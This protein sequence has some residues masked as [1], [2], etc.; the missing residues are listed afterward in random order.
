M[1]RGGRALEPTVYTLEDFTDT[2]APYE[3]LYQF[4]GDKFTLTRELE[5][6]SKIAIK[7]GFRG[8][9][10]AYGE[11]V[12]QQKQI[13]ESLYLDAVTQFE[14]QPLELSCGKWRA[15]EDGVYIETQFGE[16]EAC[17]HPIL[18]VLRLVNIDT[19]V[20]KLR[21]AYRKGGRWRSALAEKKTL[22]SNSA[23][24]DLANVGVAVTSENSRLLVRY[25]HDL[26]SLNYHRIPEKQSV[27]R[28]GWV[29]DGFSPYVDGLVF[30]GEDSFRPIFQAVKEGGSYGRW[31]ETARGAR[32]DGSIPARMALAGSFASVLV[33]KADALS[34]FVHLWG[35]TGAGKTVGL[36]LAASVW[37]DPS[38]GE[39]LRTFNGSLVGNE[40][41]AGFLGSMPLILDEFQ[42]LKNKRDFEQ[43][44]YLLSEGVG[45]TRGAKTGGIQRTPTWKNCILTSGE[46][47]ITN[48]LSG[49]GAYNR[50]LE[51]ECEGPLFPNPMEIVP[52]I[53]QNYGFAGREFV[54]RLLEEGGTGE[55]VALYREFYRTLCGEDTTEKQAMAGAL[56]LAADTLATR[57]IF[58]DGRALTPGE[59]A[60]Y[61][62]SKAEVDANQRAYHYLCEM[63]ATNANR[64]HQNENGEVW[65]KVQ[66]GKAYIIRSVFQH[67]CEEGGYS[68]RAVLS[69]MAKNGYIDTY[70]EPKTGKQLYTV[71]TSTAGMNTRHV[72]LHL[73][74]EPPEEDYIEDL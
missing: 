33:A 71:M 68:S 67:L 43:T 64:F 48:F 30:D 49:G 37:A 3:Y 38:M 63:V 24:L 45:K 5:K 44:V 65:G 17:S 27:G 66:D 28:L 72:V 61:L 25:L 62:Q 18:P 47:P 9:K 54:R 50:I 59:L 12:K 8:M 69:W 14:D 10:K 26:E 41:L 1:T 32:R 13:Q 46:M 15:G 53:R 39:Y 36:M 31:L 56:L 23:I 19:G 51:A 11:Y 60:P 20:E 42:M 58:E 16:Q 40:Q 52:A 34:F 22:A 57:W 29:E 55:A 73:P 4:E 2:T 21:L 74:S 35:G 70:R 6:M 7:V